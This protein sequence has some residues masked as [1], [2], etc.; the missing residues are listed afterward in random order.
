MHY[1]EGYLVNILPLYPHGT[2]GTLFTDCCHFAITDSELCCPGCDRKVVG[3]DVETNHERGKIR[4]ANAT[5]FW[6]RN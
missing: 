3:A 1:N 4:W 5:R 2:N 6:K